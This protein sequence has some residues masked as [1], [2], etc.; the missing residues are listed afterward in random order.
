MGFRR[1]E[2]EISA[3]FLREEAEISRVENRFH[4]HTIILMC[5]MLAWAFICTI[6]ADPQ[7]LVFITWT[8]TGFQEYTDYLRRF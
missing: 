1:I 2:R 5:G 4:A 6:G 3:E 8:L 7:T